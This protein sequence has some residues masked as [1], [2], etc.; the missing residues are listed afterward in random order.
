VSRPEERGPFRVGLRP[1]V[2]LNPGQDPFDEQ[3]RLSEQAEQYGFDGVFFGDRMLAAV[4]QD[5]AGVYRSSHTDLLVTLTAVAARTRR[6]QLGSLVLVVPLRHP[7]PLAKSI[8]SL[9][10]LSR[11]RLVLGVGSGWNEAEFEAVGLHR[12]DG[13]RRLR[14]SLAIMRRLWGGEH[15][16][17]EGR[18]FH[19][20]D[21]AVEPLPARRG[22][23]PVWMGSFLPARRR[24]DELPAQLDRSLRSVAELGDGWAPVVYTQLAKRTV[25]PSVLGAA[26]RRLAEHAAA[27]GRAVPHL[28]LSHWFHVVE[29]PSDREDLERGLGV[30]FH[31]TLEQAKETYLI[32]TAD[33]IAS[34]LTRLTSETGPPAWVIFSMLVAGD[35]Q[36][37]LLRERVLPLLGVRR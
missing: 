35:R 32:G 12:R 15:V 20:R 5:G 26:W 29:S 18:H 10:L 19:L 23:P 28:A 25:E 21:V 17:F 4:E 27:A 1:A 33:E 22:G 11:G 14:E 36:L 2:W 16:D 31:G 8:A 24:L 7:V 30:F 3:L 6:I 9:D 13:V 37:E 34:K